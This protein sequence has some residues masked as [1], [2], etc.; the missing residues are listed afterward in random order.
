MVVAVAI[1]VAIAA[2][3]GEFPHSS[4]LTSKRRR[5][6]LLRCSPFL[7]CVSARGATDR[8]K[9]FALRQTPLYARDVPRPWNL[10]ARVNTPEGDLDLRKRGDRDFMITIAGRVL[11]TSVVTCSELT[12]AQRGCAVVHSRPRPR[13][14][15]GGLGLGFTLRAALD[16]LP[17]DAEVVVAELNPPVVDWCRGPAASATNGAALDPRVSFFLGDVTHEIQRVAEDPTASRYDAILWDLYLGPGGEKEGRRHP[18]YGTKS[19]QRTWEALSVGGV[20]GVWGETPNASFEARLTAARFRAELIRTK[21][22]GLHHVV[23][24]AHREARAS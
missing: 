22:G 24:L 7:V 8:D 19:V 21:G 23:Y 17:E 9:Q 14:L 16:A 18:L 5:R 20:F 6:A 12:L 3:V 2:A 1:A 10:L 13:I 15:I 11:M 4:R